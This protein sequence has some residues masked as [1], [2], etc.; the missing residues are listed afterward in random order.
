[1]TTLGNNTV[2]M[3]TKERAQVVTRW[4]KEEE[5]EGAQCPFEG[6]RRRVGKDAVI[7]RH[8]A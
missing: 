2:G 4:E 7:G 5:V 3:K 8:T 6:I 1:M